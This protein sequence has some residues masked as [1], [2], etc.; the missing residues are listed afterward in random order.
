MGSNKAENVDTVLAFMTSGRRYELRE[1]AIGLTGP[2]K[3]IVLWAYKTGLRS[4][5]QRLSIYCWNR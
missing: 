1:G 2:R 5:N 3:G 4:I